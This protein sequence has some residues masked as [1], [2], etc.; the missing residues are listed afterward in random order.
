MFKFF[1]VFSLGFS[2]EIAE[3]FDLFRNMFESNGDRKIG[4]FSKYF[5]F[6]L[7]YFRKIFSDADS[8]N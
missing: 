6:S 2:Q 7:F 5:K 4:K 1:V 8:G 3:D